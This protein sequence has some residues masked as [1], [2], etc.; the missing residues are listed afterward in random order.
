[1]RTASDPSGG[2]LGRRRLMQVGALGMFGLNLVSYDGAS[3]DDLPSHTGPRSIRACILI[4][5]Y[6]GPSHV[7]T[8]DM[9]PE[10][11]AEI[12]GEF[13]PIRTSAPGVRICEHLPLTA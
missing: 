3:A 13:K 7:D 12:R 6:G 8:W 10:A 11:P 2:K 1:M 4:F 9:K 5:Y